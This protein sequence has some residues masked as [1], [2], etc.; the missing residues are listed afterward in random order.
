MCAHV[1]V[2]VD[3]GVHVHTHALPSSAHHRA[4]NQG[5]RQHLILFPKAPFPK[6]SET[7]VGGAWF[8]S[9]AEHAQ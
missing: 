1:C 2:S 9:I 4:Q 8:Q 6:W 7:S 3:M 5:H